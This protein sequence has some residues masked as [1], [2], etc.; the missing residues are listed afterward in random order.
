MEPPFEKE[1]C[2]V[3]AAAA[4]AD[5][6]DQFDAPP[7][8]EL[9]QKGRQDLRKMLLIMALQAGFAAWPK[10]WMKG[11]ACILSHCSGTLT[12]PQTL[13]IKVY[14]RTLTTQ[15]SQAQSSMADE[16]E[17]L[18]STQTELSALQ[19]EPDIVKVRSVFCVLS[20]PK[21]ETVSVFCPALLPRRQGQGSATS[22]A[23]VPA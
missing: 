10:F 1:P 15:Q 21:S 22:K 2:E 7:H 6:P 13:H 19:L 5:S 18:G 3:G 12:A 9:G 20:L 16:E 4:L 23:I 11:V 17:V 14:I 8:A